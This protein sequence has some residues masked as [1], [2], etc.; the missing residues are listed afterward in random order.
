MFEKVK[1]VFKSS[2]ITSSLADALLQCC[3][4]WFLVRLQND[5]LV[6]QVLQAPEHQMRTCRLYS[7]LA[8]DFPGS[9]CA[10]VTRV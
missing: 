6:R 10:K 7:S 8:V 1:A 4:R 5:L 3:H 2:L 9:K